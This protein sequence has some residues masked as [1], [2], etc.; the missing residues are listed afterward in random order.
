M[1]L[2]WYYCAVVF[3]NSRN[4]KQVPD[5]DR[6]T[7]EL[8]FNEIWVSLTAPWAAMIFVYIFCLI[9]RISP[10]RIRYTKTIKYLDYV[11]SEYKREQVLRYLMG[12]FIIV[13]VNIMVFIYIIQFTAIHGWKTSWI[14]WNTG[15]LGFFINCAIYD[16]LCAGAHWSIYK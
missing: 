3:N 9:M 15:S 1:I 4:P 13:A 2:I 7:R 6:K 16:P 10:A 14:W 8:T 5:F 12:Y 11:M